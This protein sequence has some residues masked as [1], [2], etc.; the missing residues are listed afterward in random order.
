MRI[1]A[2]ILVQK[3]RIHPVKLTCSENTIV[4][5]EMEKHIIQP[6]KPK[7]GPVFIEA[8]RHYCP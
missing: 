2:K 5:R 7:I 3:P 1:L 4:Y 8:L 6:S